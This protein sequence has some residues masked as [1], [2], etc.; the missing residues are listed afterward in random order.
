MSAEN[1][2]QWPEHAVCA[3][4]GAPLGEDYRESPLGVRFCADCFDSAVQ[5]K[6][7]E[8]AAE[9]YLRGHCSNCGAS[10]INGYRLSTLGVVYC[11]S[12]YDNL[13]GPAE[14]AAV[15]EKPA[16]SSSPTDERA[17]PRG[18]VAVGTVLW[19]SLT[20]SHLLLFV[21][22]LVSATSRSFL[23]HSGSFFKGLV[24]LDL[25][26]LVSLLASDRLLAPRLATMWTLLI[27]VGFIILIGREAVGLIW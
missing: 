11:I 13:P 2:D 9:I 4:C 22:V 20:I 6:A 23:S 5:E 3:R 17:W 7:R 26:T 15:D 25:L 19:T 16:Q 24:C 12:C 27:A 10:L 8:R 21:D 14:Q 1:H 18:K